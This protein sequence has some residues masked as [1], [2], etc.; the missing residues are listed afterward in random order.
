MISADFFYGVEVREK[1]KN[2]GKIC[3]YKYNHISKSLY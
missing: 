2:K 1:T 3:A